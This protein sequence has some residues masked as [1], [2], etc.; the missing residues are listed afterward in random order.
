MRDEALERQEA[1]RC[2][3]CSSAI[4]A[5]V[6]AGMT[7]AIASRHWI[8][9]WPILQFG[10][11]GAVLLPALLVARRPP[12]AWSYLALALN[13]ASG[14]VASMAGAEAQLERGDS[15]E[16]FSSV[17]V[18][19]F[20]IAALSPSAVFGTLW[21]A[22]FALAPIIALHV[23]PS[24]YSAALPGVEP[25]MTA[26]YSLGALGLLLCRRRAIR[27]RRAVEDLRAE[28]LARRQLAGMSMAIRDLGN[29]PLQ[30]LNAG[31]AILRKKTAEESVLSR[32]DRAVERLRML[33]RA[34]E[35][36]EASAENP[37]GSLPVSPLVEVEKLMRE[38]SEP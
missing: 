11:V 30:T 20:V 22:A 13:F 4:D 3:V 25:W 34:L 5:C 6:G 24:S 23:W 15:S 21:I 27:L 19:M 10:A 26:A 18:A 35:S 12:V 8:P 31:I 14:L 16:L 2:A 36:V 17:K 29:T 38:E 1:W 28:R 7:A 32:M 33:S 37:S 9:L